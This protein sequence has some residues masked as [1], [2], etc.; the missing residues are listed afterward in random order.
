[1]SNDTAGEN[2]AL[3]HDPLAWIAKEEEEAEVVVA[4][5]ST[6]PVVL[7]APEAAAEKE[8]QVEAQ[9]SPVTSIDQAIILAESAATGVLIVLE[10]DVGIVNVNALHEELRAALE[11]TSKVT[12]QAEDLAH[13]DTAAAQLLYAFARDAKKSDVEVQWQGMPEACFKIFKVLGLPED[14]G[15]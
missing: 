10:G 2:S 6:A 7:A 15:V 14:L 12:I 4:E 8:E 1:M 11:Q 3:G 9:D 5:V 13:I